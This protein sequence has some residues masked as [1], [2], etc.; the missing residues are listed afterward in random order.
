VQ[1]LHANAVTFYFVALYC[2]IGRGLYYKLYKNNISVWYTGVALFILSL[3]VA[4]CG[5]VL[6]WSQTSFW[7]ATVIVNT[8]SVVPVVGSSLVELV[9]GDYS[10]SL[11]ALNRFFVLHFLL[12]LVIAGITALHIVLLHHHGSSSP[13]GVQ[14]IRFIKFGMYYFKKDLFVIFFI[15]FLLICVIAN[16]PDAF[17]HH[18]LFN[19]A[20][21]L[22]TPEHIVPEW[23]FLPFY[24]ILRAFDNKTV[25]IAVS[26]V[27][28]VMLL[29]MPLSTVSRQPI[30][31]SI[32]C[33]YSLDVLTFYATV[34]TW[35]V[36]GL[37]GGMAPKAYLAVFTKILLGSY[38]FFCAAMT[39][40]VCWSCNAFFNEYLPTSLVKAR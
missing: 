1:A 28:I 27:P 10:A 7:G 6:P 22:V 23:Y 14:P 26:A 9:L 8:L 21:P 34:Y 38:F 35:A 37:V 25:G 17:V 12:A 4:F 29:V 15:L 2:H 20:N 33:A 3:I 39:A 16:N 30:P 31:Y 36:L 24:A 18:D 5:Y 19:R 40:F 11:V 13:L 32:S